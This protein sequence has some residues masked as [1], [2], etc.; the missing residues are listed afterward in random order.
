MFQKLVCPRAHPQQCLFPTTLCEWAT[1]LP[2]SFDLKLR[3][4]MNV[5]LYTTV[6]T[7]YW[8]KDS[9]PESVTT[10]IFPNWLLELLAWFTT[11]FSSIWAKNLLLK[12]LK[13]SWTSAVLMDFPS[14]FSA[15]GPTQE[16]LSIGD[17]H[18]RMNLCHKP[19]KCWRGRATVECLWCGNDEDFE[20]L[21]NVIIESV[22]AVL[23]RRHALTWVVVTTTGIRGAYLF[24]FHT[25]SIER[26]KNVST[27]L[28]NSS[29][30]GE[31]DCFMQ[32]VSKT[33]MVNDLW[34]HSAPS[35]RCSICRKLIM[36]ILCERE[37]G[38][39]HVSSSSS[40]LRARRLARTA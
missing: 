12:W 11:L 14:N 18:L 35:R 33:M 27:R 29:K 28:Y 16:I 20:D 32:I 22:E 24:P 30:I 3:L 23:A 34:I 21:G 25:T 40:R 10:S 9:T 31:I 19:L 4:W 8:S 6:G 15:T 2:L 1:W 39:L 36:I 37:K 5:L 17:S 7:M 38:K 13:N 26:T